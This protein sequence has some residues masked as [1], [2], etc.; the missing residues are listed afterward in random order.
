MSPGGIARGTTTLKPSC[1]HCPPQRGTPSGACGGPSQRSTTFPSG[2]S[3][4]A[5]WSGKGSC[6]S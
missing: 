5:G 3:A 6:G 1:V 4:P 2:G